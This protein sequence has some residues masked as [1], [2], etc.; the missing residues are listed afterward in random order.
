MAI[1]LLIR[2]I[3]HSAEINPPWRYINNFT[4]NSH[5]LKRTKFSVHEA[6]SVVV[7]TFFLQEFY[8]LRREI[9]TLR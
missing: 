6:A 8:P 2:E 4:E 5:E 1:S 3:K 9:I 7:R